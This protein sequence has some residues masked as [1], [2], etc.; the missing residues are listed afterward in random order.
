MDRRRI[1]A[2][3]VHAY[4]AS[5][6]VFA[7]AAATLVVR[8]DG[9]SLRLALLLLLVATDIDATDGVL[10]RQADVARV[11]PGF[12]GRRLDDIIDF[13]T[14]TSLPLLLIWRSGALPGPMGWILIAPLIASAY[15]FAQTDAKTE[16]GYFLG[17][18][19]YWNVVAFY[20]FFLAPP[21]W[22]SAAAVLILAVLT[23]VPLRYLYPSRPGRLNRITALLGAP[24]ALLLLL[25][26]TGAMGEPRPWV[27]WSLL[28]PAWYLV[29]SWALSWNRSA[30]ARPL[31]GRAA[32]R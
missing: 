26:L 2:W 17:F 3:A 24:W 28:F 29:A 25:I 8:G 18:P 1:G 5:G 16:D 12:D 21:P 27:L 13:H 7:A 22:V 6:L 11:V 15:G 20:L 19:S 10:A 32:R 4:T 30:G 14:Y 23:F 9:T 31:A